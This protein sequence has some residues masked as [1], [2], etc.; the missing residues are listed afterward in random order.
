MVNRAKRSYLKQIGRNR[1][2][3][4]C[5]FSLYVLVFLLN[6]LLYFQIVDSVRL[7]S[8]L[9]DSKYTHIGISP[10]ILSDENVYTYYGKTVF[11]SSTVENDTVENRVTYND[12]VSVVSIGEITDINYTDSLPMNE[13]NILSGDYGRLSGDEIAISVKAAEALG[14]SAGDSVYVSSLNGPLYVTVRYVYEELYTLFEIDYNK[15]VYSMILPA[16]ARSSNIQPSSYLHYGENDDSNTYAKIYLKSDEL[17]GLSSSYVGFIIF[18]SL[19][20]TV[21]TC[22]FFKVFNRKIRMKTVTMFSYGWSRFS[23]IC[24]Q[25][26]RILLPLLPAVIVVGIVGWCIGVYELY[27]PVIGTQFLVC[28]TVQSIMSR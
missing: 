3:V 7:E 8:V 16:E 28:L 27:Y 2:K 26:Y 11:L 13:K 17:D 25:S 5:L 18:I 6:L 9:I 15:A 12:P 14:V 21:A 4:L 10:A 23:R 22:A 20:V 1:S 24:I 19:A